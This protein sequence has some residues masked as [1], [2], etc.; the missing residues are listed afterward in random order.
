MRARV[1]SCPPCGAAYRAAFGGACGAAC[2]GSGQHEEPQRKTPRLGAGRPLSWS[3]RFRTRSLPGNVERARGF[4]RLTR[5]PP[6]LLPGGRRRLSPPPYP[7]PPPPPRRL[8]PPPPTPPVRCPE[9]S[10]CLVSLD[11]HPPPAPAQASAGA[12]SG[13][14]AWHTLLCHLIRSRSTQETRVPKAS[15]D[16]TGNGRGIYCSPRHRQAFNSGHEG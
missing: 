3:A 9:C 6:P 4:H 5:R 13:G 15:D 16:V 2:A 12:A 11:Q 7:T 1:W 14:R 10:K 8:C